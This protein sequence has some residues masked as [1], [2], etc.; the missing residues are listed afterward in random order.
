M[1]NEY[2]VQTACLLVYGSHCRVNC[3]LIVDVNVRDKEG[4]TALHYAAR[5]KQKPCQSDDEDDD[6]DQT[7][8]SP[9][10]VNCCRN[11]KRSLPQNICHITKYEY[12]LMY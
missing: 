9:Q 2:V 11:I 3:L 8:N 1:L 12:M 5:Y 7:G 6:V 4:A 10:K